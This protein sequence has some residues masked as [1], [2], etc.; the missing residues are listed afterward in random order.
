MVTTFVLVL[1][2]LVRVSVND[3]PLMLVLVG[4]LF[5]CCLRCHVDLNSLWTIESS[6]PSPGLPEHPRLV[7]PSHFWTSRAERQP[8]RRRANA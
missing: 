5:A 3:S 6:G 8:A 2:K 4:V 1:D 7:Q